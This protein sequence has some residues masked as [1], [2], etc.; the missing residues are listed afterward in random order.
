MDKE[1]ISQFI[2]D[3]IDGNNTEA[4]DK[5]EELISTKVSSALDQRKIELANKIFNNDV[6]NVQD[7]TE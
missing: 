5:F 2:D 6:A 4:R 3:V 1:D 7:E